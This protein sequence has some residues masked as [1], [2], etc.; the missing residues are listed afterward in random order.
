MKASPASSRRADHGL[1]AGLLVIFLAVAALYAYIGLPPFYPVHFDRANQGQ[2]SLEYYHQLTEGFVAGR[3][4]FRREPEPALLALKDPYDPAQRTAAGVVDWHDASYFKGRYYLYFGA[5]PAVALFVPFRL[6]TGYQFSQDLATVLFCAGGFA[7]SLALLVGLRRRFFPSCGSG[8]T[9]AAGVMLGLGNLCLPMLARNRIWEIP[10]SAAYFFSMAGFWFALRGSERV[11]SRLA[12][13]AAASFAFGLATASRPHFILAALALAGLWAGRQFREWRRS[14]N[15]RAPWW[16]EAI[17]VLLP[18]GAIGVGLLLYNYARFES[19]FEFGQKYQFAGIRQVEAKLMGLHFF[20]A[21]AYFN[22]LAPAQFD[23]YFPFIQMVREYPGKRADGYAGAEDPYGVFASLPV[24]W[25]GLLGLLLFWRG[26][27]PA[28]LGRWLAVFGVSFLTLAL[29]VCCFVS[30]ANRY[31][32][33]F[34]P[35]LLLLSTLGLFLLAERAPGT[36][37]PLGR[38]LAAAAVALAVGYSAVFNVL[39]ALRHNDLFKTYRPEVFAA[40]AQTLNR[41]ALWWERSHPPAYGPVEMT[42][43]FPRDLLGDAEPLAV[44][45]V[46]YQSDFIYAIFYP[47]QR[48]VRLAFTHSGQSQL[49]GPALPIDYGV[50]HQISIAAGSLYPASWH[51]YFAGKAAAEVTAA[52]HT[53]KVMLDGIP[54]LDTT[55]EFYDASPGFVTFGKNRVSDFVPPKF[56]GQILEVRRGAL[57][58]TMEPFVGEGFLQLAFRRPS[59]AAGRR[60]PLVAT[61]E[62]GRRDV[63]FIDYPDAQ[64]ARFGF[65]HEGEDPVFSAPVPLPPGEI[66]VLELS[67]GS[68]Y[69]TPADARSRELSQNVVIRLGGQTLWVLPARF[70]P[71]GSQPPIVGRDAGIAASGSSFTGELLAQHTVHPF[72]TSPLS[73]FAVAPYWLEA[74]SEPAYGAVRLHFKLP[75]QRPAKIE[76]LLVTG[77]SIRLTDYLTIDHQSADRVNFGYMHAGF[78]GPQSPRVRLDPTRE[79]VAEI[80]FPALYPGEGDEFFSTR[81][82]AEIAAL[83]RT[84]ARLRLNGQVLFDAPVP[85]FDSPADKID[86]GAGPGR[87]AP[88]Y[89]DRFSGEISAIERLTARTPAG[90]LEN[91]GPLELKLVFPS[92]PSTGAVETLCAT[93]AADRLDVLAL[94]YGPSGRAHCEVRMSTGVILRSHEFPVDAVSHLLQLQWGGLYP[95][96][97]TGQGV[98]PEEQRQRQRH[99]KITLDGTVLLED[100]ADFI[101]ANL[102]I[103]NLGGAAPLKTPFTGRLQAVRRLP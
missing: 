92:H 10:I 18:V 73:S 50:P 48:Q 102:Q 25:L 71:A 5:G 80:D 46:S 14:A 84:R 88:A 29:G 81:T 82:L 15:R 100:Q 12:W 85:A 56:T 43:R 28:G 51:P 103:L 61:G 16:P 4:G 36:T 13:Y 7:W 22:F 68:F 63:L 98:S 37:R 32:V 9:L 59:G 96:S 65:I 26:R 41:P 44:T 67:L 101:S 52:K 99:V 8:W 27:R 6:L 45:G 53:L 95:D 87:V 75:A 31:E 21:N 3:A 1:R 89:A 94:V 78:H 64:S 19:P 69:R 93:G 91:L 76:P 49:V 23:R 35:S 90:L 97:T 74:G 2:E 24:T 86:V 72:A 30:S 66:Q 38:G 55:S 57:P 20:P 47:H 40:L 39:V 33:D 54:C 58:P 17:A 62:P 70:H 83:R 34:V 60:E 11:R 79:Q 42:V 77:T